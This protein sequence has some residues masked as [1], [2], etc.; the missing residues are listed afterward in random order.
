VPFARHFPGQEARLFGTAT[1]QRFVITE[2]TVQRRPVLKGDFH[3]M[4]TLPDNPTAALQV[5]IGYYEAGDDGSFVSAGVTIEL[6]ANVNVVKWRGVMMVVSDRGLIYDCTEE[7]TVTAL[8]AHAFL[9]EIIPFGQVITSV[10]N[11]PM[12]AA[13]YIETMRLL[14]AI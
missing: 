14:Q 11:P 8:S 12:R 10:Q 4:P 5:M 9:G 6:P 7:V 2:I 1:P 3:V 13:Y